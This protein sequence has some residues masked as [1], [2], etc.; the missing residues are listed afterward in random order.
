MKA[1]EA[2]LKVLNVICHCVIV[3]LCAF[4]IFLRAAKGGF[5]QCGEIVVSLHQ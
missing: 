4:N 1:V 2:C 3:I 5:W